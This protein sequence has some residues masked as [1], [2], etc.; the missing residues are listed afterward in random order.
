VEVSVLILRK[1]LHYHPVQK[2]ITKQINY[3]LDR[4][5]QLSNAL[6]GN[7]KLVD[8][9]MLMDRYISQLVDYKTTVDIADFPNLPFVMIG[10]RVRLIGNDSKMWTQVSV[11]YPENEQEEWGMFSFDSINGRE[12]L[13]S[14]VHDVVCLSTHRGQI[15]VRIHSIEITDW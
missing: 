6:H 12:L 4:R 3:I 5:A 14:R 11:C 8:C 9:D 13:L 10:S 15:D 1:L 7:D 2:G